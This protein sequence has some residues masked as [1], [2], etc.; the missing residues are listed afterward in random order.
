M[1]R[2]PLSIVCPVRRL[3]VLL[4]LLLAALLPVAAAA[5]ELR[6]HVFDV[7][8][9]D[10]MLIVSPAGKTVL[11]DAGPR[12][13]SPRLMA[14][15][16]AL[17]KGQ[18]D[19]ELMTHPHADHI[20]GMEDVLKSLGA[21]IFMEPGFDHPSPLYSQ[22]LKTVESKG[23]A[24]KVGK[25]GNN[26]EIGG[27]ASMH[28]LAP[29]SPQLSG[30]RS[31]ANANSIVLRLS[32]GKT[33]FYLAADSEAETERRILEAGEEL[34]SD[35]YK[36]AHHASRHSSTAELLEK[37]RPAVAVV[38]VGAGNE[39][40]HPTRETLDRLEAVH[41]RVLRTDLD[42]E[43]VFRSDGE[44][45]S[46][47]IEKE[48]GLAPIESLPV[49]QKPSAAVG[50]DVSKRKSVRAAAPASKPRSSVVAR[51][52]PE[53]R[54]K[55]V[56]SPEQDRAG[57]PDLG[58]TQEQPEPPVA[59]VARHEAPPPSPD[60]YVASKNSQV[61]HRPECHNAARIKPENVLHF[62]TREEAEGSARRPAKDCNP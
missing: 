14:R 30:T 8:Q 28:L 52:R 11:V 37:V 24:L 7:G 41:A 42:G 10:A 36:V 50:A 48:G 25:A 16:H 45:V 18:I 12:E 44:R 26:V 31:D 13:A 20:G 35:V 22:L 40:G 49:V 39:Y 1:L 9:G 53:K 60:G 23:I 27:G 61:Y 5:G 3:L 19:L 4:S 6:V 2:Y 43:I 32:Y 17:V 54:E 56:P 33:A 46:F 55:P 51:P 15:L 47:S 21:R 29:S 58:D 57:P 34:A 62:V 38:S 59:A